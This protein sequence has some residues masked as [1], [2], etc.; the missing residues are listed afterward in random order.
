MPAAAVDGSIESDACYC[1]L[2]GKVNATLPSDLFVLDAAVDRQEL[3]KLLLADKGALAELEAIVHPLVAADRA[4]FLADQVGVSGGQVMGRA[5]DVRA[6][7]KCHQAAAGTPL[8]C[9][10]IPLLFEK[11]L[12]HGMDAILVVGASP[13]QQQQRVLA[14]PGMTP[15][16]FQAILSRQTVVHRAQYARN[17]EMDHSRALV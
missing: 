5:A 11:G 3:S 17:A 8:V 12:Q 10:D 7:H 2:R 6:P 4:Q 9:L 16:K 14:R 15:E 1:S 13:E